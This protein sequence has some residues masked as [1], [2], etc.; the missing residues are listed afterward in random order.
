MS[1]TLAN[2][3]PPGYKDAERELQ[4]VGWDGPV[5]LIY[6]FIKEE[7]VKDQVRLLSESGNLHKIL[8]F[9]S[10][11]INPD[12][13]RKYA[14]AIREAEKSRIVMTPQQ[15]DARLSSVHMEALHELFPEER[16]LL[17]RR[18]LEEVAYILWKIGRER[19]A[20]QALSAAV[21]LKTPFSPIEPNPFIWNLLLKSIYGLIKTDYEE[22]EE[23]QKA[24]LIVTP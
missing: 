1:Q 10:W 19:E 24:S 22:K 16:R 18:R 3:L 4:D 15:K 20:K 12:K 7:E 6:E 13:V 5:A 11:F 23:E 2:P 21:D 8:P 9:S 14:E 17:W